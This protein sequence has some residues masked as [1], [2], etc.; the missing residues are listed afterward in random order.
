[1]LKSTTKVNK[2]LK[3]RIA[4]ISIVDVD[5]NCKNADIFIQ[6]VLNNTPQRNMKNHPDYRLALTTKNINNEQ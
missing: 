4:E 6:R 3:V 1:L 5:F 2:F